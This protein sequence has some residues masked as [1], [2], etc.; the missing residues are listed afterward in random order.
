[1]PE[2]DDEAHREIAVETYNA[3]W[4]LVDSP[5]RTIAEEDEALRLAFTSRYH[6][7]R[8]GG[9]EEQLATGDWFIGH[10]ASHLGLPELALR[11]SARALDRVQAAGIEGWLLAS[12]Y[13]GMARANAVAGNREERERYTALSEATLDTVEDPDEREVIEDQLHSIPD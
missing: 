7:E 13:E 8:A 12:A 4:D 6:W 1:M 2:L 11:F 9:G 5:T 10:V 3:A